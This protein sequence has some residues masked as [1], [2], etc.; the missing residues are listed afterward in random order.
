MVFM[1]FM[2]FW[3]PSYLCL[4]NQTKWRSPKS[5]LNG[6]LNRHSPECLQVGQTE[7]NK[8]A[9]KTNRNLSNLQGHSLAP[10]LKWAIQEILL[11]WICLTGLAHFMSKKTMVTVITCWPGGPW[12]FVCVFFHDWFSE[13][14]YRVKTCWWVFQPRCY[15]C[16]RK[17]RSFS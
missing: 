4:F 12:E 5:A 2:C 3:A 9:R 15:G 11:K 16:K 8:I 7:S 13:R 6:T 14:T 1:A 17:A 10:S